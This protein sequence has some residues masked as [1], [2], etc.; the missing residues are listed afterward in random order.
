LKRRATSAIVVTTVSV[1]TESRNLPVDAVRDN[2]PRSVNADIDY[3]TDCR[4]WELERLGPVERRRRLVE[5]DREWDIDRAVMLLL[6]ATGGITFAVDLSRMRS[7]KRWN[8]WL[9][10]F[11]V[12][13]GFMGFDAA[14]GWCP[15]VALLR[16][17]GIRTKREIES[18]RRAIEALDAGQGRFL[19]RG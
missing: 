1:D 7:M 16:R 6:R 17:L 13:V 10:L 15:H 5:L 11:S 14:A 4:L 8:G 9:S 19:S 18:E 2:T 3:E 12:Q